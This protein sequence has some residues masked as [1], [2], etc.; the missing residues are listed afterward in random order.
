M[1]HD[2]NAKKEWFM[3]YYNLYR[4]VCWK[5]TRSG[6]GFKKNFRLLDIEMEIT[7]PAIKFMTD[8]KYSFQFMVGD[9]ETCSLK[10]HCTCTGDNN[11]RRW[12]GGRTRRGVPGI[13]WISSAISRWQSDLRLTYKFRLCVEKSHKKRMTRVEVDQ[14]LWRDQVKCNGA[15]DYR[16][17]QWMN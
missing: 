6:S 11:A 10:V 13:H 2:Q 14:C 8:G 12:E 17:R 7:G 5:K 15:I 9:R 4:V 1:V 3:K 16:R